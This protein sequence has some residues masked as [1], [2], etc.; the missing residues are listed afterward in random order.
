MMMFAKEECG[1]VQKKDYKAAIANELFIKL[2]AALHNRKAGDQKYISQAKEVWNWFKG[3]GMINKDHL[4][5]DGLKNCAVTGTTFTYNQGV[6][7]GGL[8]ELFHA[9]NDNGYLDDAQAIANAATKSTSLNTN[10]ILN[11][12]DSCVGDGASFKGAF[13]RGLAEL[14]R[15]LSNHPYHDYLEKNAQSAYDHCRNNADQYSG[16]WAGPVKDT[17]PGCQHS[18]L[19]LMN[20]A[21]KS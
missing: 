7:L 12:G 17:S 9:T 19:D 4:I 6:I 18:A 2:A 3:T 15:V 10:G 13:V 16:H 8:V 14:S 5:N 20:A 21:L 11:E 1:G